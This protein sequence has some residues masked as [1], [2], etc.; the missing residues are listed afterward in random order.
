[1]NFEFAVNL[2]MFFENR[3]ILRRIY[4][5]CLNVNLRHSKSGSQIQ[6]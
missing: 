1:M 2:Q 5:D 3:T 4:N 6:I